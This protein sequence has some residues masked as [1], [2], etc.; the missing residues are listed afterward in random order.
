MLRGKK[1]QAAAILEEIVRSPNLAPT[2]I[3]ARAGVNYNEV[4]GYQT[5]IPK[6]VAQVLGEPKSI[7]YFLEGKR[8]ELKG[9]GHSAKSASDEVHA[10]SLKSHARSASSDS[11]K[12]G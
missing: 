11:S 3:L 7:T 12:E 10:S 2:R 5:S 6:P 8:V 9:N 4:R 1:D